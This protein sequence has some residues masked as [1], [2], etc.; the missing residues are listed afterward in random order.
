MIALATD[1]TSERD[2][3]RLI[4][5]DEAVLHVARIAYENPTTPES[6]RAMGP[7]LSAA[8]DL[9]VPGVA[10]K[11]IAFA[12]TSASVTISNE[13]VTAAIGKVRPG[14]PV[15]TPS[16]AGLAGL[17]AFGARRIALLTPYLVET[18]EPMV[19]YFKSNGLEITRTG[20]FGLADDRQ[21]ARLDH[22]T[23]IDAAVSLDTPET[24]ALFLSCT[25]L[26]AV[27]VID[28]I[29]ARLGKPV[30]S[31]NQASLWALRGFAGLG[32]PA[33]PAGRLFDLPWPVKGY[34]A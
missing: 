14:V 20:C 16:S 11:A 27:D 18:T 5:H 31:S 34:A 2:A 33:R 26:P 25:A 23:L 32:A 12:C 15:V 13:D 29:E 19:A 17:R 3:S 6:L 24:E 28:E 1:L 30:V 10:L 8:A 4:A 21:M 7:G 22:A 9:L